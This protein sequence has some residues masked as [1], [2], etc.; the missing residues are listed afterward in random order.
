[1][2][3]KQQKILI[4]GSIFILFIAL[5]ILVSRYGPQPFSVFGPAGENLGRFYTGRRRL[6]R[7]LASLDPYSSAAFILFQA[8]QVVISPIPGELTGVVGGYVYGIAFGFLFSTVG[9]TL[10]SWVAFELASI[11]GRPLAERF[12]PEKILEKFHFLTTNAGIIVSFFLFLIPGF[13]KDYLCYVLG[14][15]GMKLSNFLIVSTVGRMPGTFLLTMQGA[16]ISSQDYYTAI[17][18]AAVSG[19][20]VLI[21]YLYRADLHQWVKGIRGMGR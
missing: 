19:V 17:F 14:L 1:M 12:V 15:T 3:T 7:F 6:A 5:I 4:K 2:T 10:G 8:L 21:A 20:V 16:S 11:F 18:V 13:P 9:L